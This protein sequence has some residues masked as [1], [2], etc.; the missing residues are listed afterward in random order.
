MNNLNSNPPFCHLSYRA[1]VKRKRQRQDSNSG[2]FNLETTALPLRY[3]FLQH[4]WH[5]L[6]SLIQNFSVK[7]TRTCTSLRRQI[8]RRT[9]TNLIRCR[10]GRVV[11]IKLSSREVFRDRCILLFMDTQDTR[12][13][14]LTTL[15]QGCIQSVLN[16]I[17]QKSWSIV[18]VS[19]GLFCSQ[20]VCFHKM[21]YVGSC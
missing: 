21:E 7:A 8:T 6:T 11:K 14:S 9:I 12:F 3:G 1:F 15:L 19:I 5:M 17:P 13:E 16:P 2:P 10:L 18:V 4:L 20:I